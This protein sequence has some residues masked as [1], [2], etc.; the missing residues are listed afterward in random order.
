M[1]RCLL[2]FLCLSLSI[3]K[4][5]GVSL[6]LDSAVREAL[7]ANFDIRASLL[8]TE[9]SLIGI[10]QAESAFDWELSADLNYRERLSPGSNTDQSGNSS[11][12][13]ETINGGLGLRKRTS[14]GTRVGLS[15]GNSYSSFSEDIATDLSL[16]IN[17]PLLSGAGKTVNLANVFRRRVQ[18]ESALLEYRQAVLNL[19][20]DVSL[21]YWDLALVQEERSLLASSLEVA[22]SLVS[23]TERRRELGLATDIEVLRAQVSQCDRREALLNIDRGIEAASDRL[24]LLQGKSAIDFPVQQVDAM[25]AISPEVPVLAN[26]MPRVRETDFDLRILQNNFRID[27]REREVAERNLLPEVGL[28]LRGSVLGRSEDISDAYEDALS[29][30]GY[31]WSAGVSL[32]MPWGRRAEKADLRNAQIALRRNELRRE[33]RV[34]GIQLEARR[35]LRDLK[36]GLAALELAETQVELNRR[37]FEQERARYRAGTEAF[38]DVLEAQRTW[39]N[40]ELSRLR[41]LRDVHRADLIR[42]RL[43]HE[44]FSRFGIVWDADQQL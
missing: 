28:T 2:L 20:E 16:S 12:S 44:L 26:W 3:L 24:L 13:S 15:T 10:E 22:D 25:S 21:A 40:A 9:Q 30:S 19:I 38:R 5:Q 27:E 39:D 4:G 7:I 14:L 11:P 41:R 43:D 29:R 17:Q 6:S 37:L 31:N 36:T 34:V 32:S 35:V 33:E 23:E 1:S 42:A 8:S 18:S